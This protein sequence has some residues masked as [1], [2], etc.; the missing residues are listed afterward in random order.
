MT[1]EISEKT[2]RIPSY[3]LESLEEICWRHDN[4]FIEDISRIL[5]VNSHEMKKKILG[6][7]GTSKTVLC[8]TGSWW[9]E[10]KCPGMVRNK[11]GIWFRCNAAC[12]SSG[13]CA[14]HTI[15]N[16]KYLY[17]DPYFE[18]IEKRKPFKY[19]DEVVW[20]ADDGSVMTYSG[21]LLK[22]VSINI[23]NGVASELCSAA[24]GEKTEQKAECTAESKEDETEMR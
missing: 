14:K 10:S 18:K 20:V 22:N 16:P 24:A 11:T 17:D 23:H 8:E 15:K 1:S 6:V 19:N 2:I 7:R 9:M 21:I 13:L 4:K 12:E 3:L 5:G